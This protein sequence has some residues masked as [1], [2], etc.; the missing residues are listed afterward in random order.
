VE[1][2]EEIANAVETG[3]A[4]LFAGAG[5]SALIRIPVWGPYLES[6]AGEAERFEP[7]TAAL[8]RKRITNGDY[9]AAATLFKR[10]LQAPPGEIHAALCRPFKPGTYDFRPLLPLASMPFSAIVTTNYDSSLFEA[11]MQI[12]ARE[13]TVVPQLLTTRE[14]KGAAYCDV[15]FVLFLHGRASLPIQAERIVFDEQDYREC[16]D[17]PSFTDGLLHL[18]SSRTC[19]FLGFSFKDP[20]IDAVLRTWTQRRGP[21]FPRTHL[22]VLPKSAAPL[23]A[24][25]TAMNVRVLAYENAAGDHSDLWEAVSKAASLLSVATIPMGGF[26]L[27]RTPL[28]AAR[29]MLAMCYARSS[30]GNRIEPLRNVVLDGI[31][32]ALATENAPNGIALAALRQSMAHRLGML[33]VEIDAQVEASIQRLVRLRLAASRMIRS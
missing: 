11:R 2:H 8:M 10:I 30:L 31:A 20:G 17:E 21:A 26:R 15:P 7:E 4:L 3:D 13:R 29:D 12:A 6:L 23:T 16:Y 5:C 24:Q 22:A 27:R 18:L 25:L 33:P 9:L 1:I 19:L 14:T 32:L 28:A